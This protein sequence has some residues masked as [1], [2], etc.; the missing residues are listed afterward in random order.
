MANRLYWHEDSD[1]NDGACG[2]VKATKDAGKSADDVMKVFK[3]VGVDPCEEPEQQTVSIG[4]PVNQTLIVPLNFTGPTTILSLVR[5]DYDNPVNV[6]V[7]TADDSVLQNRTLSPWYLSQIELNATQAA[8]AA[9]LHVSNDLGDSPLKAVYVFSYTP[10]EI[11]W[12]VRN[13][14]LAHGELN[15]EN[16]TYIKFE[17]PEDFFENQPDTLHMMVI[18]RL[19]TFSDDQPKFAMNFDREP[20]G[21]YS[22]RFQYYGSGIGRIRH[23]HICHPKPGTYYLG[24]AEGDPADLLDIFYVPVYQFNKVRFDTI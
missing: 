1:F 9:E 2:V 11:R 14:S 24:R 17:I 4:V 19:L 12:L 8:S 5:A 22:K 15:P 18:I 3:Q 23:I 16:V 20:I 10:D 6:K 21:K 7:V 13:M